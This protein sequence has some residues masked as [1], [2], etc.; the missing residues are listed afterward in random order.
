MC[1]NSE[2]MLEFPNDSEDEKSITSLLYYL[3]PI[4]VIC[5]HYECKCHLL[6]VIGP[7]VAIIKIQ[8]HVMHLIS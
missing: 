2:E 5:G 4:M 3:L 7:K 6:W 8:L 1:L